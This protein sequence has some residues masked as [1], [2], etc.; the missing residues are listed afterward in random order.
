MHQSHQSRDISQQVKQD[1]GRQ[2]YQINPDYGQGWIQI[3]PLI[4]GSS[5]VTMSFTPKYD[6]EIFEQDIKHSGLGFTLCLEGK[7]ECIA[8]DVKIMV[9]EDE[10]CFQR[11]QSVC[12]YGASRFAKGINHK[13]LTMHLSHDWLTQCGRSLGL[14][15]INDRYWS[16][17]YNFG[18][19]S[20]QTKLLAST[21]YQ[22]VLNNTVN[23]H[24]LSAKALEL[25]SL[26]LEKFQKLEKF[27][28]TTSSL[29]KAEDVARIIQAEQFIRENYQSP[30]N[31]LSLARYIGI[32]DN[33]LKYGFKEIYQET[34]FSYLRKIRLKRAK[35]LLSYQCYSIS[36]VSLDVG[37]TSSSHFA[38]AFKKAYGLSPRDYQ[39][40]LLNTA[41]QE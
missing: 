11:F 6:I 23:H 41:K 22:S 32:N 3:S 35:E 2:H 38:V 15:I 30:P 13:Y 36:K 16:G 24:L 21:V 34:V 4:S 26:Q 9:S 25:W 10:S 14:A 33:K 19:Y 12:R 17:L 1:V 8:D 20:S 37:Y 5:L 40:Q 27:N 29:R 18:K 7:V 39:R 31:L 28:V